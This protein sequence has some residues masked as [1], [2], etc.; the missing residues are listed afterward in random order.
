[1]KRPDPQAEGCRKDK[2]GDKEAYNTAYNVPYIHYFPM[3]GLKERQ[4]DRP[5]HSGDVAA[6]LIRP[7]AIKCA[8]IFFQFTFK[9]SSN[10]LP[11]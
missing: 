1:M 8:L 4:R 11:S 9:K 6:S 5:I 2:N 10:C 3:I 7:V